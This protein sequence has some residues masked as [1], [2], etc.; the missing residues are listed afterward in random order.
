MTRTAKVTLAIAAS[1]L[2]FALGFLF[3]TD[4][5]GAIPKLNVISYSNIY[6]D[7]KSSMMNKQQIIDSFSHGYNGTHLWSM[8]LADENYF[9]LARLLPCRTVEYAGGP[10]PST[11]DSCDQSLENEYSL[12][13]ILQ[14]QKWL[15]DHQHPA[16]CT[17]KRIAI[18]HKFAYSGFGSILHQIAWAFGMALADDRIAVYAKPGNWVRKIELLEIKFRQQFILCSVMLIMIV[19]F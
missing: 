12:P 8:R 13:N 14:A 18:I 10:R 3:G 4:F 7:E 19:F 16:D 2:C 9:R 5:N 11:I 17:N 15:Y 1:I 6:A